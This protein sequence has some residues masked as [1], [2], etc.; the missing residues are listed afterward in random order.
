MHQIVRGIYYE[1]SFPG[2][3][4]GAILFTH[5]TILIDAPLRAE[6]S[7]TWRSMLLNAGSSP[8]RFLVN[9]DAHPDRTLGARAM[10]CPVVAHQKTAQVF[11]NRPSVFKGQNNESGA[12]WEASNDVVGTR[13]A[14][15]DIT[16]T[17][18]MVFHWDDREVL[19]KPQPG[20]TPGSIW[21]IIP[22]AK[23]IFAGDTILQDQPPFL[24]SADLPSWIGSLNLLL[25][26]YQDY[27][28]I[29]GRGGIVSQ[30]AIQSQ[31]SI[32]KDILKGMERLAKRGAS[33]E[34]TEALVEGLLNNVSL[35]LEKREQYIQRLRHGLYQYYNRRYHPVD[36]TS[37]EQE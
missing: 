20:P 5:A 25:T 9:L 32:L 22:S 26:S 18:Q 4:L 11:R 28:V 12:E 6:D 36:A 33:S 13:W 24:A 15:P 19:L 23:V 35:P 14:A 7:R 17:D 16:F 10:D 34:M 31:L 2:V 21:V 37:S 1:T 3:T 27:L 8:N 29:S 30:E